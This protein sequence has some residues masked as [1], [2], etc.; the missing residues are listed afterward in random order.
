MAG[1]IKMIGWL[2]EQQDIGR[3]G[4]RAGRQARLQLTAG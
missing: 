2:V 1:K 3:G 4:Q